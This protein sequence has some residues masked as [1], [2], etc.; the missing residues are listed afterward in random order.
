MNVLSVTLRLAILF[1]VA[2][3]LLFVPAGRLDLPWFWAVLV[4]VTAGMIAGTFAAIRNDPTLLAE[5]ARPGPGGKDPHLRFFAGAAMALGWVVA[6]LDVRFGWSAPPPEWARAVGVVLTA[7]AMALPAW[8]LTVNRFFSSD[9]RIQR[10]RGHR[11]VTSG[12]YSIIRHP[13]YAGSVLL[14][15]AMPVALGSWW[16]YLPAL[17]GAALILRRLLL[18]DCLLRAELEGYT[19]YAARVP[20]RLVPHVW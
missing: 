7:A 3:A 15:L 20:W 10:D 19:E 1:V 8:A 4:V 2:G 9:A 14:S 5:R 11:V 16:S 12:P 17:A 18:E 6:G 13:G